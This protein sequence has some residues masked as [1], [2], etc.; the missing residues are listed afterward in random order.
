M[1]DTP[2]RGLFA[3]DMRAFSHGCVRLERP[4]DL[5]HMLLDG[6]VPDPEGLF[7]EWLARD[8]E[9]WVRI[10]RPVQVHLTYRTAWVDEA[11]GLDQFRADV[12]GRDATI[13]AALEGAGLRGL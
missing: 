13:W 12:Y 9:I 6:Q 3:K 1:H 11:S 4:V 10:R 5:A 2:S 7:D 8:D